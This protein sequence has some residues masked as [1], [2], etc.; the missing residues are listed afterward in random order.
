MAR[1]KKR[2]ETSVTEKKNKENFTIY[3]AGIYTSLSQERKEEYIGIK[4]ILLLY[5]KNFV[6]KKPKKGGFV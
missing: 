2:Y 3:Q 4:A 1:T 5:R 6:S